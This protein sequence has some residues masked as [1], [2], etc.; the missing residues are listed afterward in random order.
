VKRA[1]EIVALAATLAAPGLGVPT[2]R[3][4]AAARSFSTPEATTG[5]FS[6][7]PTSIEVEREDLTIRCDEDDDDARP[8]CRFEATYH[9]HNP[10]P[11]GEEAAGVF[12]GSRE[13]ELRIGLNGADA[14]A[15]LDPEQIAT[16]DGAVRAAAGV[17]WE[18]LLTPIPDGHLPESTFFPPQRMPARTGFRV[19]LAGG[20]RGDLV[21]AGPLDSTFADNPSAYGGLAIPAY[22]ARHPALASYERRD[23]RYAYVYLLAPLWTWAGA[24]EVSVVIDVPARWRF[25]PPELARAG[26]AFDSPGA[27]LTPGTPSGPR[28][29]PPRSAWSTRVTGGRAIARIAAQG[30]SSG[31]PAI[32]LSFVIPGRVILNGGPLVGAG[33]AFGDAH[34]LRL[35]AGYEV[36]GPAWM[37]YSIAAETNARDRFSGALLA[38]AA[39]PDLAII[40]PSAALGVGPVV[41]HRPGQTAAGARLQ[42]ASS[43]PVVTA[44]LHVDF[45]PGQSEPARW[46]LLGQVSF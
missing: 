34:G 9:L 32:P 3:A 20:A 35:R 36:A 4:N 33:G 22:Q 21:F 27:A 25:A 37:L 13:R 26:P 39:T 16:L 5:A 46:A 8:R 38:E 41:E 14:R 10:T 19:R 7:R 17:P 11:T 2:A 30:D 40:I 43:W 12:Y 28:P 6:A 44:V 15:A 42:A 18:R 23:A 1:S 29:S 31:P 45:F 24:R